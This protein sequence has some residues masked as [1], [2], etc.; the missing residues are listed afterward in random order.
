QKCGTDMRHASPWIRVSTLRQDCSEAS[1]IVQGRVTRTTPPNPN[2]QN[3]WGT[4]DVL[5]EK[6]L[7]PHPLLIGRQTLTLPEE[8]KPDQRSSHRYLFFVDVHEE[9]PTFSAYK[10]FQLETDSEL[11]KYVECILTMK[12]KKPTELLSFYFDYLPHTDVQIASDAWREF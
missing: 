12:D 9:K 6:V 7:K 4:T 11:P 5:I 3:G 2:G 1:A 10:R 8:I